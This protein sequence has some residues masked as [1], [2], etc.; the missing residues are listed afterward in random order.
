MYLL[1]TDFIINYFNGKERNVSVIN[2]ILENPDPNIFLTSIT[3]YELLKGCYKSGNFEKNFAFIRE[4]KNFATI[5]DF[6]QNCAL[7]A[8]KIYN[9]LKKTGN[10]INEADILIASICLKYECKL[11]TENIKHYDKIKDIKILK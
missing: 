1:D 3:Y 4:L 9:D 6:D 2:S 8:A 5:L 10:M 7:F 11:L